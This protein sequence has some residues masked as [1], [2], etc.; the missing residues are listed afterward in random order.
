MDS[1]SHGNDLTF[2]RVSIGLGPTLGNENRRR[3]REG[4]DPFR[5]DSRFRGNDVTFRRARAKRDIDSSPH[6]AGS[7]SPTE[8]RS[9][10]FPFSS[11][12]DHAQA[13]SQTEPRILRLL[14][15]RQAGM[16]R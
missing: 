15:Y 14:A 12:P 6:A 7:R 5:V 4:G 2:R 11:T 3:P 8:L 16:E 9:Y 10:L 13:R 1:R